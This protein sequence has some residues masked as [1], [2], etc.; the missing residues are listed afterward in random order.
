MVDL[1]EKFDTAGAEERF[2]NIEKIIFG[3]RDCPDERFQVKIWESTQSP[4]C[5][6]DGKDSRK[7][8]HATINANDKKLTLTYEQ[9]IQLKRMIEKDII[10]YSRT[11]GDCFGTDIHFP[12]EQDLKDGDRLISEICLLKRGTE[13]QRMHQDVP[14]LREKDPRISRADGTTTLEPSSM[15]YPL[16]DGKAKLH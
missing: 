6:R 5:R 10:E 3:D 1:V 8:R 7:K 4:R 11:H 12:A 16:Q 2:Q 15:V 14:G 9:G 13:Q